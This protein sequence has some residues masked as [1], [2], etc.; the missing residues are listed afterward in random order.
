MSEIDNTK[1]YQ[2]S[3]K[4]ASDAL[5]MVVDSSI[6]LS[7]A[8]DDLSASFELNA[9][10]SVDL[11][12][13]QEKLVKQVKKY[14]KS[15]SSNTDVSEEMVS[16]ENERIKRME[17][18]QK[19]LDAQQPLVDHTQ[20]PVYN[21]EEKETKE[22]IKE[23]I[24]RT[25]G[26]L[27][28]FKDEFIKDQNKTGKFIRD[29]AKRSN[30]IERMKKSETSATAKIA[31][32]VM[33]AG[34]NMFSGMV[35]DLLSAIPGYQ[36]A[37]E[38]TKFVGGAVMDAHS[39][40]RDIRLDKEAEAAYGKKKEEATSKFKMQQTDSPVEKEKNQKEDQERK[41]EN[42]KN[43][44]ERENNDKRHRSL[45]SF[46]K[47][48]QMTMLFTKLLGFVM[49]LVT[50][51][52]SLLGAI[53]GPAGLIAVIGGLG[54]S[55]AAAISGTMGKILDS[56][57]K[58]KTPVSPKT[59]TT[60]PKQDPKSGGKPTTSSPTTTDPKSGGKPTTSSPTPDAAKPGGKFER[61]PA[62]DAPDGKP[63][64]GKGID[65]KGP[66]I[67]SGATKALA[68]GVG[69][70]A[71]AAGRIALRA[72]PFVGTAYM[73]YEIANLLEEK[74][75][76]FSKG[77]DMAMDFFGIGDDKQDKEPSKIDPTVKS[78][79]DTPNY[80]EI[81]NNKHRAEAVEREKQ[82]KREQEKE[83]RAV[84]AYMNMNNQTYHS[85]NTVLP[86]SFGP[87]GAEMPIGSFGVQPKL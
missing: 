50:M 6:N 57:F 67:P 33:S 14:R 68:S 59:T 46:L 52:G 16:L 42:G 23:F 4:D 82:M 80:A 15:L 26:T 7:D 78:G 86:S 18:L 11:A 2:S 66:K 36:K 13:E 75:G 25:V 83:S 1:A 47:G 85:S 63:T 70:A 74:T 32:G 62:P 17:V 27:D 77:K 76:V 34:V 56:F 53:A 87:Y 41:K 39:A 3:L 40:R 29:M 54:A 38:A 37:K 73:V 24:E 10:T 60:T 79:V 12:A 55:I 43:D 35:D 49:P 44:R 61:I 45:L 71:K 58:P 81:E 48:M 21:D 22:T 69:V 28:D 9:D 72:I 84:S 20:S 19:L 5:D 30:I 65:T 8:A 64:G 51:I 31:G